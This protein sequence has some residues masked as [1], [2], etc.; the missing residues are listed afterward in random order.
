MRDKLSIVAQASKEEHARVRV[1][2]RDLTGSAAAQA[3]PA[4]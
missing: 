1:C 4:V 2:A 3:M